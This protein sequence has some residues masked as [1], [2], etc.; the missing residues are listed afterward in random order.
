MHVKKAIFS[1][2]IRGTIPTLQQSQVLIRNTCNH[3][4]YMAT[5]KGKLELFENRWE[6][7]LNI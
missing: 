3:E 5:I 7:L 1:S 2:K 4:R 6:L